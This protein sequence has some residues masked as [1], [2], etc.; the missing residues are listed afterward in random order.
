MSEYK[1]AGIRGAPAVVD[2]ASEGGQAQPW[3]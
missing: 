2:G 1:S 3:V